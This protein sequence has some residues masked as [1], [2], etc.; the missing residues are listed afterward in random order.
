MS[1][2]QVSRSSYEFRD[3][4]GIVPLLLRP[5]GRPGGC[6]GTAASFL[7]GEVL[8]RM[9]A[10]DFRANKEHLKISERVGSMLWGA[11]GAGSIKGLGDMGRNGD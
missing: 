11:L 6:S 9:E 8:S 3:G 5:L 1:G 4:D 7:A 2:L 10:F